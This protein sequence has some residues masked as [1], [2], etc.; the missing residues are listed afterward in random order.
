MEILLCEWLPV[1]N[2]CDRQR[3]K[4]RA[5]HCWLWSDFSHGKW[6]LQLIPDLLW[7]GLL[8]DQG[9]LSCI[10]VLIWDVSEWGLCHWSERAKN[11]LE[12]GLSI[13]HMVIWTIRI[14]IAGRWV[15]VCK[16]PVAHSLALVRRRKLGKQQ[17][18]GA[19]REL[20][21]QFDSTWALHVCCPCAALTREEDRVTW[22]DHLQW[23]Q[24]Q[25]SSLIAPKVRI[26]SWD[27]SASC[28]SCGQ[29]ALGAGWM[30]RKAQEPQDQCHNSCCFLCG[31][32]F[33]LAVR[34][35]QS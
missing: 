32:G 16:S 15:T 10:H 30:Q 7:Q 14:W 22:T 4:L 28:K 26:E 5:R 23:S 21:V 25:Q 33:G 34:N 13:L 20:P 12:C 6:E 19:G 17:E 1:T 9:D 18:F 24:G 29:A 31:V 11:G 8:L 27:G 35:N 2:V 3:S